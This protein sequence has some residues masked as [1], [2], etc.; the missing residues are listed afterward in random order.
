MT[1]S[2]APVPAQLTKVNLR[3]LYKV[4]P[5][6]MLG[7]STAGFINSGFYALGPVY[8]ASMDFSVTRTAVFM[9]TVIFSGLL[10]QWPIGKISDRID[11]R[12]VLIT[13]SIITTLTCVGFALLPMGHL[14]IL[15][16]LAGLYGAFSFVFYSVSAAH[17]ND[18]ADRNLTVQ[19]AGGLLIF[20]GFGAILGPILTSQIMGI[21]G[22]SGLFISNAST[23]ILFSLFALSR[24]KIRASKSRK[25]KS[26]FVVISDSQPMTKV[27]YSSLNEDSEKFADTEKNEQT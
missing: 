3:A 19:T 8:A 6:G 21:V 25:D 1:Q 13:V 11:R 23:T 7:A 17:T 14:Y 5:V 24:I 20:Y 10:L 16:T 18:F 22:S 2:K 12:Y 9:S 4:S 26:N 27:L 15:F